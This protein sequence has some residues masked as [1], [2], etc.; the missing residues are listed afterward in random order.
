MFTSNTLAFQVVHNIE[1]LGNAKQAQIAK[2]FDSLTREKLCTGITLFEVILTKIKSYLDHDVWRG[3]SPSNGVMKIEEC[4]EFHR[5]WSALQFV[6][7]IS[8]FAR[9]SKLKILG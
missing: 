9:A 1:K 4:S 2:D 5:L 8:I 7:C 6:Y 3:K